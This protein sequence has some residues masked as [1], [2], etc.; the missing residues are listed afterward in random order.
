MKKFLAFTSAALCAAMLFT[1]CAGEKGVNSKAVENNPG[2]EVSEAVSATFE[3]TLDSTPVAF[4]NKASD[5]ESVH[6]Q[7]SAEAEGQKV[8]FDFFVSGANNP[9][10]AMQFDAMEIKGAA[11][12]DTNGIAV[13]CDKLF[14]NKAYGIGFKNLSKKLENSILPELMGIAADEILGEMGDVIEIVE[15]LGKYIKDSVEY[16]AQTENDIYEIISDEGNYSAKEEM[17]SVN[18]GEVMA[19]V[20]DYS[21]TPELVCDVVEEYVT[22]MLDSPVVSDYLRTF[23][24]YGEFGVNMFNSGMLDDYIDEALEEMKDSVYEAF[25]DMDV[26]ELPL[27]VVMNKATGA[28]IYAELENGEGE[29][30]F[31]DLGVN[32]ERSEEWIIGVEDD[33]EDYEMVITK[34]FSGNNGEFSIEADGDE[35]VKF[36]VSGGRFELEIDGEEVATGK[37]KYSKN[38]LELDIEDALDGAN[39]KLVIDTKAAPRAPGFKDILT[40]SMADFEKLGQTIQTNAMRSMGGMGMMY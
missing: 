13:E 15:N 18:D 5:A 22:I 24:A 36:E 38:S 1:S 17:F 4:I 10:A 32:P 3:K 29:K 21:I 28:F 7:A 33:G 14:G 16:M 25:E 27:T 6:V 23:G 26:D 2:L 31:I 8:V 37:C 30:I 11:Y 39:L 12:L 35:L 19:V 9:R 20:L 34:K 40:M